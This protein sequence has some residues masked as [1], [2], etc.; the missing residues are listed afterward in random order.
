M[1]EI[2]PTVELDFAQFGYRS[3]PTGNSPDQD[4]TEKNMIRAQKI[5]PRQCTKFEMLLYTFN[6]HQFITEFKRH[7]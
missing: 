7:E 3:N 5:I 4:Q 1:I 2:F 6:T